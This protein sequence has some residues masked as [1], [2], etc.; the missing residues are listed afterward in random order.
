MP[1]CSSARSPFTSGTTSGTPSCSRNAADLSTQT[2]PP[3]T[4]CG[5]SS[6]LA[7]EPTEK[8]QRSRSPAASASGVA[9]STDPAVGARSRPSAPRRTAR[10]SSKPRSASSSSDDARRPRRSRR[11]RRSAL[12]HAGAPPPARRARRPGAAPRRPCSTSSRAHVA[13][14]L[15]RRGGDDLG[16]DPGSASVA[17]VFAATPGWLFMPAPI[18]LTLPRSSRALHCDAE[19]VE[20]LAWRRR[21]RLRAPRRRSPGRSGRSCRR[22]RSR[23]RARRRAAPAVV[24]STR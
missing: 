16:L 3:R 18:T 13:G 4:A 12:R 24:P 17:N 14:D 20:H 21:G 11:R 6:R 8:R 15:D 19:P 22:S 10:T 7:R 1:S 23:P 2:A 9:S 5:T